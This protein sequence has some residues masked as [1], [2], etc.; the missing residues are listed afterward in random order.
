MRN[1][2]TRLGKFLKILRVKNDEKQT[3]MAHRLGFASTTLSAI[4]SGTKNIPK[5]FFDRV[6]TNYNLSLSE[7]SE[8]E[9]IM[10]EDRTSKYISIKNLKIDNKVLVLELLDV[11]EELSDEDRNSIFDI[12][13]NY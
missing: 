4:E 7:E 12:I 11:I 3:E 10:I 13:R 2:I 1:K 8:L 6:R 9:D 5:K